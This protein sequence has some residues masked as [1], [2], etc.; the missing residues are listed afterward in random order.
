MADSMS[1]PKMG[2]M[3]PMRQNSDGTNFDPVFDPVILQTSV[4]NGSRNI[5]PRKAEIYLKGRF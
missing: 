4:I 1:P 3:S 5:L 2:E